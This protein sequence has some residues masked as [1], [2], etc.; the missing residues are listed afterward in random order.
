MTQS[1][2][3]SESSVPHLLRVLTLW[4]LIFYSIILIMPI[5]PIPMFGITQEPSKGHF[6]TT[7]LIAMAAMTFTGASYGRMAALTLDFKARPP[8]RRTW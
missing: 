1:G 3:N 6:V 2:Q 8:W 7:I 4:D 5:A